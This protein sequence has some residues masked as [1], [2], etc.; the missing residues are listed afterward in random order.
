MDRSKLP[1]G[2]NFKPNKVE[3]TRIGYWCKDCKEATSVEEAEIKFNF[4]Y[5]K[6][7]ITVTCK[8]CKGDVESIYNR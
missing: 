4:S 6:S 2:V 8:K 5:K 1:P 3:G 7:P